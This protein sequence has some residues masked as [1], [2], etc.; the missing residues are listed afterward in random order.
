MIY[1]GSSDQDLD[2]ENTGKKWQ[3]CTAVAP[4]A[5]T[6]P[7]YIVQYHEMVILC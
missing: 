1:G 4:V 7:W 2:Y 5:L 6:K 3:F